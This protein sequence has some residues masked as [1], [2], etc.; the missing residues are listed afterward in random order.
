[1]S[2]VPYI[3][4][5]DTGNIPLSQLDANFANVKAFANTAGYVTGSNQA[6]ITSVGTLISVSASG[7]ITGGNIATSGSISATGTITG[8]NIVNNGNITAGNILTGGL[9]SAAGTITG[10]SHLGSVVSVTGNITGGNILNN[11]LVSATS[12]ITGGNILTGGLISA[13]GTITGGNIAVTGA[14]TAASYSA[15]GNVT[16]SSHLGSVVSV[17]GNITGS[18]LVINNISS[19]DST[20]VT[21]EDGLN[22]TSG[23][24]SAPESM[25]LT[26]GVNTWI[27]STNGNL[28]A[29]GAIS[30]VGNIT[31]GNILTGGLSSVTGNITAGNILTGGLSSVTGN[32]TGGNIITTGVSS[33][34]IDV[35]VP[36]Y[37]NITET[38][39]YS[40]STT[41]SINILIANNVGYTATLNMPTGPRDGQI[42][43]FAISGNTVTLAVGTGTVLPT[44]AG[45]TVVG[46]GYRYVYRVSNTSWYRT[47]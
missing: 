5:G 38:N 34:Y 14:S 27:L 28:T 35:N 26:A 8:G 15:T 36:A 29:P 40:L 12:T 17:T 30:A 33:R 2:T 25:S 19:D 23:F 13:T 46:T 43:N 31:A 10:S 22:V 20:F 42:C 18:N 39:T 24:I 9:I 3:F 45:S 7:N 21:I 4:A 44:F 37:A 32:I 16:G 41:N 6:N 47:G 1:M 11:G